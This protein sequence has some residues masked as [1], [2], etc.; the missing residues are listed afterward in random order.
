M[1]IYHGSDVVVDK[2]LILERNRLLDFGIG[3]QILF[4]SEKSLEFCIFDH[5]EDLGGKSNG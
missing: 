1:E 5:Y 4:H 3:F 2:P